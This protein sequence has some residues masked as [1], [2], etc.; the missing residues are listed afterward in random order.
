MVLIEADAHEHVQVESVFN[1]RSAYNRGPIRITGQR[2]A[3]NTTRITP[4]RGALVF[5]WNEEKLEDAKVKERMVSLLF[6]HGDNSDDKIAALNALQNIAQETMAGYLHEVLTRRKAILE[7]I[8]REIPN[9]RRWLEAHGVAI[10]RTALNH[11][12]PL[13]GLHAVLEAF[14]DDPERREELL[15]AATRSMLDAATRKEREL[16][17][18]PDDVEHFFDRVAEF[19]RGG[20]P[21]Y[22]T[23]ARDIAISLREVQDR[24][25]DRHLPTRIDYPALKRSPHF[26]KANFPYRKPD[27]GQIK[28]WVFR[29]QAV[30]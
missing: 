28:C 25:A 5:G 7:V 8:L 10:T 2:T 12:V 19:L 18:D 17:A 29:R 27:G 24:L 14:V 3:D 13:A 23:N 22:A 6:L 30:E 1:L 16:R 15:D 20:L 21:N 11:A 26:V 4:F 9:Y